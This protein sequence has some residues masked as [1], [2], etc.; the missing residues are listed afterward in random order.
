[1]KYRSLVCGWPLVLVVGCAGQ[2]GE[3]AGA[4]AEEVGSAEAAVVSPDFEAAYVD[5]DE[6]AGVGLAPLANV[7]GLVPEDYT[8]IEPIPGLAIVVAQAGSC[9]EINVNGGFAAPGKFA[10]FGVGVVPPTGTGN[11]N[12]YQ[13]FFSTTHPVLAARLKAIG[14]NARFTP[15]LSYV[16]TPASGD[17]ANLAIGVPRPLGLAF[18]LDGPVTLPDPAAP[19][20]PLTTFNYWHST[21]RHGNVLQQNDVTGIRFGEGSGVT[22]TAVGDDLEAILGSSTLTFPFFSSPEIFDQA[23]V[24][25]QTDVF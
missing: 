11:G 22:L 7:A 9:A 20:N 6:F 1:M 2:G 25:V 24:S 23:D 4:G 5:C 16:I 17:E 10:Q 12:F 19:P 15:L 3:L 8:V 18:D 13:L 21:K 14:V